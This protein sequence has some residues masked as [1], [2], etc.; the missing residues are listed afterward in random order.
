[1]RMAAMRLLHCNIPADRL[2]RHPREATHWS[3]IMGFFTEFFTR[4]RPQEPE[5]CRAVFTM[6]EASRPAER[7]DLAAVPADFPRIAR[8]RVMR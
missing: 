7:I 3:G 6:L 2:S 4:P 5:R 8:R 1:M